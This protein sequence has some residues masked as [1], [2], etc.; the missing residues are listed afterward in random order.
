MYIG[1]NVEEEEEIYLDI[2]KP[3]YEKSHTRH[4]Q[5]NG[6]VFLSISRTGRL[7]AVFNGALAR[8]TLIAN[9]NPETTHVE[10]Y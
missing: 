9:E 3:F 2:S 10:N 8:V 1:R 6:L 5:N 4:K 7:Y